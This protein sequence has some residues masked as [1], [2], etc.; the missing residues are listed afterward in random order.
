M[1]FSTKW[2]FSITAS[3]NPCMVLPGVSKSHLPRRRG[4][5]VP[6]SFASHAVR[7][8]ASAAAAGKALDDTDVLM[9]DM[10]RDSVPTSPGAIDP[11][12]HPG[13]WNS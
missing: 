13:R 8:S 6:V 3:M 2:L 10:P 1:R 11:R 7:Q 5:A 9:G 12:E 4:S